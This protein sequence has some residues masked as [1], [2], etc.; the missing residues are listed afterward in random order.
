MREPNMSRR[1]TGVTSTKE[2]TVMKMMKTRMTAMV[3]TVAACVA[4]SACGGD[5]IGAGE[6]FSD[7]AKA[8]AIVQDFADHVV[9]PTYQLLDT[10][11]GALKTAIETLQGDATDLN[12]QAA[13]A[14]WVATREPWEQSE[15]FLFG[16]VDANGFDPALDSW[17]VNRTDLDAVLGSTDTLTP[18]FVANLETTLQGFH[19]AE[20]LLFGTGN[21]KIAADLTVRELEYLVAVVSIMAD[22]AE[23]LAASWT[24]GIGGNA[25]YVD[26]FRTAGATDN[27]VY[28]SLESAGQEIVNGMIGILDEVANGKIADPFDEQDTTLV[29]SQFS[30]N[31]ITDFTDNI[32]SVQNAY[33]GKNAAANTSGTGFSEYVAEVDAE[34]DARIQGEIQAAIDALAVISEPFRDAILDS[35]ESD[36]IR[37]AQEAIRT[38]QTTME[39]DILPL[40]TN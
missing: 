3:C 14:A 30:H 22:A 6:S 16:P 39:N 10:R 1:M 12:L 27:R 9:V 36:K 29:E 11:A 7:S 26:V 17:P 21:N 34:L 15:G 23:Q 33:L 2:K 31:S 25:A 40:V 5:G 28:P 8:A 38:A 35:S 19:T 4:V 32:L 13:Q 18:T 37:A 20:Y 24:D